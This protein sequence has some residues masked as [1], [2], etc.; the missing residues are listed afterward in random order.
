MGPDHAAL[1]A[2]PS[3]RGSTIDWFAGFDTVA[4][5]VRLQDASADLREAGDAKLRQLFGDI[6]AAAAKLGKSDS[7]SDRVLGE[8]LAQAL[9]V[10]EEASVWLVGTQPVLTFWGHEKDYGKPAEN[11]IQRIIRTRV[12]KPPPVNAPQADQTDPLV[13]QKS[14]A[15]KTEAKTITVPPA[16]GATAGPSQFVVPI[17]LLWGIFTALLVTIGIMLLRAC[18]IGLP[19]PLTGWFLN[20]CA[21]PD[22]GLYAELNKERARQATLQAQYEQL[23]REAALRRQACLPPA[24]TP[25]VSRPGNTRPLDPIVSPPPS[26]PPMRI[27][28]DAI[29]GCFRA[30]TGIANAQTHAPVVIVYCF[31]ADGVGRQISKEKGRNCLGSIGW[32]MVGGQLLISEAASKCTSGPGYRAGEITCRK[33]KN[34]EALCTET[35]PD[36]TGGF[37]EVRFYPVKN[38]N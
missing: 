26:G 3:L 4:K 5:P 8:L 13:D 36:G 37:R 20:S 38:V 32:K 6:S 9:Q 33:D 14:E 29:K 18:A 24:Q 28:R 35:Y 10:P 12:T 34:D 30:D 21:A 7:E 23:I 16:T 27:E 1:F 25:P 19:A 15:P 31:D 2:E 17:W 22:A 11:P